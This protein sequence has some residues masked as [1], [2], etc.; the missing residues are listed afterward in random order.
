MSIR[1]S[2]GLV[3]A[4]A[5][6]LVLTG[7]G[8]SSDGGSDSASEKSKTRVFTADNGKITIPA[9]PKRVV[10]TG[11]AVPALIE[12][13][14]PLVGISSWKR[15]EPMMT[16]DDLA[17]YKK[18]KKIAGEQAAETNYEA[19]AEAEPDLI[20]IGVPAPVLGDIDMKRLKSIA[21]VV[22]IGPSL[23]SAWRDLSRKQAD[24]AGAVKQFDAQK[25]TYDTK[26]AELAAKYKDVLPKLKL[27]HVG[28]YGDAAKG[29]FQREFNGSWGTNI[30]ED[31]GATY[32]GKVKKA[33]PGSA[34]VSE[35]PSI[36]ELPAAFREAD[37]LTYSVNADGS[38]PPSVKY[39]LDS[40]LW[41]NLPAVKAGKVFP[42]RY[43]EAATYGEALMTLDAIDE[44]LA[45]LL[46]R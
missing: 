40:K 45:P 13:D 38:V 5:L 1:R 27:G 35:Y 44:S 8:S 30:A 12:A 21:P 34:A 43:T 4:L 28:A 32:Y 14:A 20:V 24:A 11:Y 23:P 41:K 22:A 19:I 16:K 6:A 39:V 37:A 2:S 29:T 31:L 3:G 10:A 33:G 17:T 15:G 7:C 25:K 9:N 46:K 18:L 42:Y 26:A 36:E